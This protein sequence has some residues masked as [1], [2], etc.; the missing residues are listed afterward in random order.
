MHLGAKL[1]PVLRSTFLSTWFNIFWELDFLRVYHEIIPK[2][3]QSRHSS[4]G[5]IRH[6]RLSTGLVL[7][8]GAV[9]PA[10]EAQEASG[11]ATW[12]SHGL[13]L[14]H[15]CGHLSWCLGLNFCPY[16]E[17]PD[18]PGTSPGKVHGGG[19]LFET[20]DAGEWLSISHPAKVP[21]L[22]SSALHFESPA[23]FVAF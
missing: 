11:P 13:S 5:V 10:F 14:P 17:G 6:V 2:L 20:L 22:K 21:T 23:P 19:D 9:V 1:H 8:L 18:V 15:Q 3:G 12:W 7:S 16:R 4:L